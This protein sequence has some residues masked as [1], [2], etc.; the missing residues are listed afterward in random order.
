VRKILVIIFALVVGMQTS[1]AA[2]ADFC[3][4]DQVVDIHSGHK[5]LPVKNTVSVDDSSSEPAIH[6]DCGFCHLGHSQSY[7]A[8][9]FEDFDLP[10]SQSLNVY[11]STRFP[12]TPPSQPEK[13]NWFYFA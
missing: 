6:A 1:Y 13:P 3:V 10:N 7:T 11:Y 2:F 12:T 4:D 8:S 9:S 5:D